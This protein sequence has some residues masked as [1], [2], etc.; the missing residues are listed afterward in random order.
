LNPFSYE[1]ELIA[2]ATLLYL[3]DSSVLLYSNEAILTN[4]ADGRWSAAWG[5]HGFVL[6]GKSLCMLNPFTPH[7][8]SFRLRWQ[9][10]EGDEMTADGSWSERVELLK[11]L[12]ISTLACAVGMFVV[13]PTGL[14][15]PLG[16]YALI[17]AAAIVYGSAIVG[18]I[19][20]SRVRDRLGLG[21]M[22]FTGFA[23][24]CLACPPFSANMLR[25]VALSQAIEESLTGAG[26]RLADGESWDRLR[27]YCESRL[28]EEMQSMAEDSPA[29]A[30]LEARKR[31]LQS[32]SAVR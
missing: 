4:T 29:R 31:R 26:A 28:D 14:F 19:R 12:R 25:R 24:E 22:R 2:I 16:A 15:S 20:L 18:L 1:A 8:P 5:W 30:G 23:F 6:A 9:F 7:R 32:T 3:Y 21:G 13:L 17:P 27:A 10:E 11:R